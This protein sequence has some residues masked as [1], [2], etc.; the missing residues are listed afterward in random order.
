MEN[1]SLRR[2]KWQLQ[3]WQWLAIL[4]AT[5]FALRMFFWF[6]PVSYDDDTAVYTELATNW[7][8]HGVYGF[9]GDGVIHPT[10]IR[11]PGYP[12]FLGL[13]FLVFG[14]GH[15]RAVLIL[16]ALID[17]TAC[18][19]LYDCMRT[20]VSDR[21]GW[22]AL[23]LAIFCPFTAGYTA[24]GLSESLS[25][26]CIAFSIW[27]GACLLRALRGGGR[28]RWH[29]LALGLVL[30]Y[31]MLLRPDGVL[32]VA[33]F[34]FGV[35]WYARGSVGM[36]LALRLITLI[37][38]IAVLPLLPWTVRNYRTFHVVQPLAPRHV[39]DPGEFVTLG[40][41]RW[42]RTWSVEYVTTG[43][44]FWNVGSEK[45]DMEDLTPRAFYSAGQRAETEALIDAYNE[46]VSITPELDRRFGELAAERIHERPLSYY[47]YVPTLRVLDMWLRPRTELF[48][49]DVFWWRF[50]QHP[51]DSVI[52]VFLGL[53]NLA[54]VVAAAVGFGR[55]RVP[56][57]IALL[58]YLALRCVLLGTMENPEARY[59]VEV[60]PILFVA[61]AST[62]AGRKAAVCSEVCQEAGV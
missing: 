13:S 9:A 23:I 42:L 34:C 50:G 46:H 40:F 31:A 3:R 18:W 48:N 61:A 6:L 29:L 53:L 47:L 1:P 24:T 27:L 14:A 33:A 62:L 7:F 51:V 41:Y 39:N 55:G 58:G 19:C 22:I 56:L 17:L 26:S 54:Y 15:I 35:F 20:E 49:V 10:L 30:G 12:L 25:I 60:F 59:T 21:A 16:Q 5:G 28:I 57:A 45:L 11:L 32:L 8:H 38:L 4:L 43:N 52:A 37:G 36:R 44:V 2:P